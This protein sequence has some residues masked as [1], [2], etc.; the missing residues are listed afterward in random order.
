MEPYIKIFKLECFS[1]TVNMKFL[2]SCYLK[3]QMIDLSNNMQNT[4]DELV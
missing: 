3:Q 2:I 1:M 4:S